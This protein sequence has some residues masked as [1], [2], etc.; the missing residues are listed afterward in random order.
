MKHMRT[1]RMHSDHGDNPAFTLIEL[2]VVIAITAVLA[3]L[4]MPALARAK[5]LAHRTACTN[6]LKQWGLA[7]TIYLQD[8]ADTLP[9]EAFGTSSRLNNW[10]QVSDPSA[11]DVWYNALPRS[12]KLRGAADYL[13]QRAGFYARESLFHCPTAQFPTETEAMGNVLFSLAMNSK[14]KRGTAPVR[15]GTIQK[16]A[17]TVVFLEN[18]LPGEPKVDA[19]QPDSDLGQPASFASRF[20]ARHRGIGNLVFADGHV[21]SIRGNQVV[22]TAC[23]SPNRGK[24]IVPQIRV[25][26]TPDP[27]SNPN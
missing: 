19:A 17:Q 5:A 1:I 21:E 16:P 6:K 12:L 24:A 26:W 18:R 3:G 9:R 20:V 23:D 13:N 4:L 27:N 8:N 22:E 2:L 15:A 11:E 10:A 25:I 14:L 7:L